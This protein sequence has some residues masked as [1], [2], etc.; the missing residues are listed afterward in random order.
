[1]IEGLYNSMMSIDNIR[2]AEY[3]DK[4]FSLN[5]RAARDRALLTKMVEA[6]TK[7]LQATTRET[8]FDKDSFRQKDLIEKLN[9]R[10]ERG[11]HLEE[12]IGISEYIN[13]AVK[14]LSEIDKRMMEL[15]HD[16][17]SIKGPEQALSILRD[18]YYIFTAYKSTMKLVSEELA[19][20]RLEGVERFDEK[21]LDQLATA[22]EIIENMELAYRELSVEL[23]AKFLEPF[24][25]PNIKEIYK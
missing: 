23:F 6:E 20:S 18:A 4:M 5:N 1:M 3:K 11:D 24:L 8:S 2:N 21:I 9:R 10:L 15:Y 13:G 7:L 19:A 17:S 12:L 16:R 22:R 14:S 25:G